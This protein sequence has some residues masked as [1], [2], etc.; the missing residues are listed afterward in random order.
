MRIAK[1]PKKLKKDNTGSLQSSLT[2]LSYLKL[3]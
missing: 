2:M 3:K 1:M